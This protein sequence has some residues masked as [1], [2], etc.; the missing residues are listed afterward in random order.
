MIIECALPGHREALLALA[1]QVEHWFGPMVDDPEFHDALDTHIAAG[2]ALVARDDDGR[3]PL[4]GLLFGARPPEYHVHWLVVSEHAR[5]RG[6][7]RA[8]M[9]EATR[10]YVTG[11]GTIELVTFG[12]DHPGV[13]GG[14]RAFYAELGFEA[15]ERAAPG[16]E[17]GSRQVFRR[18]VG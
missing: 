10:R 7:G 8:L 13:V 6:V 5:G 2:M 1:A 15:G 12:A 11:P 14:S 3:T 4:G 9:A 17:G 16:P 18:R